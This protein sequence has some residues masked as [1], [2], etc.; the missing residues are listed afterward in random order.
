MPK[1]VRQLQTLRLAPDW[2]PNTNH[3]G[4]YAAHALGYYADVGI[5]LEIL[6]F[7]GEAMP[8]RKIVS[9][10]TDFGLM[11]QQSILSMRARGVDVISVAALAQPNTTTLAVL[12]RSG[13]TR[14]AEL[15]GKRY[16]SFGTEFEVAMVAEMIRQDGGAG[17]PV[18]VPA[19]KLDILQALLDGEIDV[20]WG[21]FAWEGMQAEISGHPLHHFF[22][23]EH[24]IPAEYF[25]LLFTTREWIERDPALVGAF[26]QATM[27]GYAY[28]AAN[29][30]PA[31]DIFLQAVPARLLPP[32]AEELVRR[33]LRW[34]APRFNGTL[35]G[36]PCATPW[37]WHDPARW[38]AFTSFIQR[39]AHEHGV[40]APAL[41]AETT[42]YSN[43]FV[44]P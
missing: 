31:A 8:N 38:A 20:T 10:E 42:G 7:D 30:D 21:F 26:V 36:T 2:L 9:G 17:G 3:A 29:P 1:N 19:E 6:P 24:G 13:I 25:P 5:A 15:A 32:Y 40:S 37:G 23:A 16:A 18:V 39:L 27:R 14:P 34:L 28:A 35:A 43:A 12:Q 22:V 44:T 4:F 41:D 33:S 11:P